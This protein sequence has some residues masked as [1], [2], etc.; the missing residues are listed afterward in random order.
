M[1]RTWSTNARANVDRE[2][3]KILKEGG[4]RLLVVGY[5][6]GNA[7]ILKNVRKGVS[8]ERARAFTRDCHDVGV[9]IHGAFI[10]GLP[11]ESR[12][13]IKETMRF[14]REMNP[15]TIEK[16]ARHITDFSLAAINQI[17]SDRKL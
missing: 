11:G 15:E 7:Q 3:L 10:L 4:L 14:A 16:V 17:K 9:L 2:T 12:K 8:L 13:T 6:S 5:E 1:W